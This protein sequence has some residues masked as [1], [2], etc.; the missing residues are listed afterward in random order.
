M[1]AST[2]TKASKVNKVEKRADGSIEATSADGNTFV[3]PNTF[4]PQIAS[5][6]QDGYV[7]VESNGTKRWQSTVDYESAQKQVAAPNQQ[8]PVV[9]AHRDHDQD[10]SFD[11]DVSSVKPESQRKAR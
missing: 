3:L 4:S 6:T 1:V 11:K 8:Q 9:D 5:G 7:I 10:V 2:G